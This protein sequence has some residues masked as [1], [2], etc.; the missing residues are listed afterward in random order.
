MV[1]PLWDVQD[2]Q[3]HNYIFTIDSLK[4]HRISLGGEFFIL[5]TPV[6]ITLDND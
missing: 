3:F 4:I 1:M 6:C 5:Q 2:G